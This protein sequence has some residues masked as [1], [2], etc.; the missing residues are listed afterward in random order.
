MSKLI[1]EDNI[2]SAC[3]I[4]ASKIHSV[5]TMDKEDFF[6]EAWIELSKRMGKPYNQSIR[7]VTT[8]LLRK[9]LGRYAPYPKSEELTDWEPPA[10]NP[11]LAKNISYHETYWILRDAAQ[12]IAQENTFLALAHSD[13]HL[14]ALEKSQDVGRSQAQA[15]TSK[16]RKIMKEIYPHLNSN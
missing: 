6:Q 8:D 1:D 12:K 15:L 4:V 7:W 16:Y 13:D 3:K 10:Y 9:A 2:I 14:T 11:D 5:N